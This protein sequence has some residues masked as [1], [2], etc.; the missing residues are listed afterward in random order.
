MNW[1]L[2]IW[3]CSQIKAETIQSYLIIFSIHILLLQSIIMKYER[4]LSIGWFGMVHM[5]IKWI[6]FITLHVKNCIMTTQKKQHGSC[7]FIISHVIFF[8]QNRLYII[9]NS[10]ATTLPLLS[11]SI[12][13]SLL[14]ASFYDII[15]TSSK[16]F[17]YDFFSGAFITFCRF[18]LSALSY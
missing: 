2:G 8:M 16:L 1:A 11:M 6:C 13:L 17:Q 4:D 14:C 7:S 10:I 12:R 18:C 5:K 3:F 9:Y 15:E